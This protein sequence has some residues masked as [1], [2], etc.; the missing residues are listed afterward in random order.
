VKDPQAE[1]DPLDRQVSRTRSINR[2]TEAIEIEIA[3]ELAGEADQRAAIVVAIPVIDA[4]ERRLNRSPQARV[5]ECDDERREQRPELAV[6]IGPREHADD[7]QHAAIDQSQH[8]HNGGGHERLL[9]DDLDIHQPVAHD[10]RRKRQRDAAEQNRRVFG[11]GDRPPRQY[12]M[13]PT[14]RREA[15]R[16]GAPDDPPQLPPRRDRSQPSQRARHQRRAGQQT[17]GQIGASSC[18]MRSS[19]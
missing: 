10:G 9:E 8:E 5:D 18:S 15:S 16:P 11:E 7:E 13:T 12:G 17:G 2:G 1:R 14:R 19:S 4:I 3:V 6:G